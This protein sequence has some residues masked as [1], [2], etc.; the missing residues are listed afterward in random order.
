MAILTGIIPHPRHSICCL[1]TLYR[2]DT[3]R[4]QN[5]RK[6]FAPEEETKKDCLSVGLPV[7]LSVGLPVGLPISLRQEAAGAANKNP[8]DLITL[9]FLFAVETIPFISDAEFVHSVIICSPAG[10]IK[11]RIDDFSLPQRIFSLCC[12]S[13]MIFIS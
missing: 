12:Y 7:G 10:G 8:K 6:S 4:Q 2:R 5:C 11:P 13:L 3:N 9:G 1:Y